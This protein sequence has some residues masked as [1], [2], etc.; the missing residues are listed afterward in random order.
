MKY[1]SLFISLIPAILLF[2]SCSSGNPD[3]VKYL[4]FETSMG[5]IK[6]KLYNETPG[7][8]ENIIKLVKEGYYDGIK[9]RLK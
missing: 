6:L 8:K 2:F 4:N 1:R 5:D 9:F 7:H 3:K